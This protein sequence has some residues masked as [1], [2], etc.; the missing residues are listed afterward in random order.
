MSS[1]RSSS[2]VVKPVRLEVR[3]RGEIPTFKNRKRIFGRRLVTDPKNAARM[4][5]IIHAIELE[6]YCAWQISAT[7]MATG[8]SLASWIASNVPLD[9]SRFWIQGASFEFVEVDQ[10]QEGADIF[11]DK[12]ADHENILA[13]L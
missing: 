7:G 4:E 13:D 12:I 11:I 5:T 8:C 6:L 9:D 1:T 3:E 2:P 10:G